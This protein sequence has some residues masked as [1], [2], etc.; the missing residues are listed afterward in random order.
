MN[1]GPGGLGSTFIVILIS[2]SRAKS[3]AILTS[4]LPISYQLWLNVG[5]VLT[6]DGARHDESRLQSRFD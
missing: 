5:L 2:S 6:G 4:T 1:S 3:N